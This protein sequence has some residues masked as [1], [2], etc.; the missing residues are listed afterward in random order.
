MIFSFFDGSAETAY[1][2]F[3]AITGIIFCVAFS[4][5][6]LLA[7]NYKRERF[8]IGSLCLLF[9]GNLF[10]AITLMPSHEEA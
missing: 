2:Y 7:V 1:K 5:A 8:Y 9:L 3:Y 4:V 10:A 6:I